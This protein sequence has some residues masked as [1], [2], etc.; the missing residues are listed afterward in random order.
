[1]V[2]YQSQLQFFCWWNE[3][4]CENTESVNQRANRAYLRIVSAEACEEKSREQYASGGCKSTRVIGQTTS[5]S[6]NI[7]RK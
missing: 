4:R 6:S 7:G 2:A 3:H 5:S 1:M